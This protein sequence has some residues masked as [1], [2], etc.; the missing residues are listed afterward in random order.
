MLDYWNLT[1]PK[2]VLMVLAAML[3]AGWTAAESAE[4][5]SRAV[6]ARKW[7][8]LLHA[9]LGTT[10]VIVGAIALNQ[11]PSC[12]GDAKMP[13]TANRPLPSGRL[14]GAEVTRFGVIATLL[15]TAYLILFCNATLVILALSG[16]VIYVLIYTPLKKR[17]IWQTPIGAAAGAMPALLGAAAVG[18]P[19]SPVGWSLFGIVLCWQLPHAMAIAWLYRRQ[20]ADA[21][22]RVAAAV[23]PS[24][25]AAGRFAFVGAVLLLPVSLAPVLFLQAAWVYGIIAALLG[26]G[27]LF[28]SYAFYRR[29]DDSTARRLLWASLAYLPLMLTLLAFST[30]RVV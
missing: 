18:A 22:V 7:I 13:R 15:G 16:W 5:G 20:F 10:G 8:G 27:Y 25:R 24:G 2:I 19:L 6:S 11:R 28:F 29:R 30:R 26:L 17:S 12:Q 14:T 23:D 21:G 1:R 9:L 3:A 4:P